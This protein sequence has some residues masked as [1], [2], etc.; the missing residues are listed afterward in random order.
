MRLIRLLYVCTAILECIRSETLCRLQSLFYL[1]VLGR[2]SC[3]DVLVKVVLP[4]DSHV[5]LAVLCDCCVVIN[6]MSCPVLKDRQ[7]VHIVVSDANIWPQYST[8]TH[9]L[10]SYM[11]NYAY[12]LHLPFYDKKKQAN[13]LTKT[14]MITTPVTSTMT[15]RK[16]HNRP[17]KRGLVNVLRSLQWWHFRQRWW[18]SSSSRG[19]VLLVLCQVPSLQL[20]WP[21]S[22]IRTFSSGVI[23]LRGLVWQ[24]NRILGA[25]SVGIECTSISFCWKTW[26]Q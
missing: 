24:Y 26:L 21:G 15:V 23:C 5:D 6:V 19:D 11:Y 16:V 9:T 25:V 18:H 17:S 7:L 3:E 2:Y 12:L 22:H 13:K 20:V 4:N 14:A 8:H 10:T 1:P